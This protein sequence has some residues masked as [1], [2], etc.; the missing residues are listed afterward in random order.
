VLPVL[1]LAF[2]KVSLTS[3]LANILI[4]PLIPLTMGT[5]F[6]LGF[7]LNTTAI[8]AFPIAEFARLLTTYEI[9]VIRLAAHYAIPIGNFFFSPVALAIYYFFLAWF[10]AIRQKNTT[11]PQ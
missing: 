1:L 9:D 10:I 5:G 4:L 3:I 2:G 7:I 11:A 8:L 6:L